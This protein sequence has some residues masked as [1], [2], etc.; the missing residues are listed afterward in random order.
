MSGSFG[1]LS[2]VIRTRDTKVTPPEDL[3]AEHLCAGCG[4][5]FLYTKLDPERNMPG[6]RTIKR[7]PCPDCGLKY[8]VCSSRPGKV[9]LRRYQD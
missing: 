1:S 8:S 3:A 5:R 4:R 7:F 9:S 2:S 6:A